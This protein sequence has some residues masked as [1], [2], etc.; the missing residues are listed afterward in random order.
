MDNE[1]LFAI[2]LADEDRKVRDK[3]LAKIKNYIT[4]RTATENDAFSEEDLIKLWKG[5]HYCMWMCDKA[6]IQEELNE[7]I[8]NLIDCFNSNDKQVMMF[9]KVYFLTIVR[10]W[11]GIDK[12]RMDKFMMMM[13]SMLRKTLAYLGSRKWDTTLVKQFNKIMLAYPL[14]INQENIPDGISYHIA[15][16]YLEELAKVG[17]T[18]KPIRAVKMLQMFIKLMA[19]SKKRPFVQHVEKRLF[20]QIIECSDVGISPE[21]ET[22]LEEIRA[23]GLQIGEEEDMSE[24]T[25]KFNYSKIATRLFKAANSAECITRNKKSIYDLVKKFRALAKDVYP[26]DDYNLPPLHDKK[27]QVFYRKNKKNKTKL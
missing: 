15:D 24:Y 9:V 14:N 8:C 21:I 10:E 26:I 6:I 20:E 18:L 16:I 19:I 25:V 5:L 22:E 13:R 3:C 4:S 11:N 27:K 12:W 7:R 23:N 1:K 17:E 2:K